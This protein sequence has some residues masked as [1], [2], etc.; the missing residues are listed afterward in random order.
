MSNVVISGSHGNCV[1]CGVSF[2]DKPIWQ[3]FYDIEIAKG[4]APAEAEAEA[5]R[6]AE[7]YGAGRT[8]G[9]FG[10]EVAIVINDRAQTGKCPD[11]GHERSL[12]G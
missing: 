4:T 6:V 11:C 2:D 3:Y 7:L 10:R 1:S 9:W 5:D 8:H 12:R